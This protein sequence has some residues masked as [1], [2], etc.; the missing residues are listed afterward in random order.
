MGLVALRHVVSYFPDQG[1][2]PHSLHWKADSEPLDHQRSPVFFFIFFAHCEPHDTWGPRCTEAQARFGKGFHPVHETVN[3][4]LNKQNAQL[5]T[6][7]SH[8][9]EQKAHVRCLLCSWHGYTLNVS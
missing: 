4:S 6:D 1:S 5:P 9:H 8:A 7:D 3:A 2:N